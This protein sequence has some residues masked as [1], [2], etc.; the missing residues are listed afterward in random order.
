[1][2]PSSFCTG[3]VS[4]FLLKGRSLSVHVA[5]KRISNRGKSPQ[6]YWTILLNM[7]SNAKQKNWSSSFLLCCWFWTK[8]QISSALGSQQRVPI[9]FLVW[10]HH[11]RL[12]SGITPSWAKI[13]VQQHSPTYVPTSSLVLECHTE[14]SQPVTRIKFPVWFVQT[15]AIAQRVRC[16]TGL[17]PS[18]FLSFQISPTICWLFILTR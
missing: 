16:S 10:W 17:A 3:A 1:M 15:E 13:Y 11:E 2:Y 12:R 7:M 5:S 18:S 8:F 14:S 6:K 4:L 9:S